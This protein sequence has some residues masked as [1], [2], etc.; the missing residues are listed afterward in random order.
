[1]NSLIP[2]NANYFL[3]HVII[4]LSKKALYHALDSDRYYRVSRLL[5][6]APDSV[7]SYIQFEVSYLMTPLI[8]EIIHSEL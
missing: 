1:M 2:Q 7:P 4:R 5:L 6:S 8:Y 3:N